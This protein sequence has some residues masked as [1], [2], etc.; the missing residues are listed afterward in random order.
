MLLQV[1]TLKRGGEVFY[2]VDYNQADALLEQSPRVSFNV[3]L[4]NVRHDIIILAL[5]GRAMIL[6]RFAL[7]VV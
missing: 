4:T 1:K 5:E 2:G 7:H 3:D 6:T